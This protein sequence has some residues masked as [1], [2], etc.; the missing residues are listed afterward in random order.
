[1]ARRQTS[2]RT[3]W[4]AW[5]VGGCS[6]RWQCAGGSLLHQ[7][8]SEGSL[9]VALAKFSL[10]VAWTQRQAGPR[11]A[12]H[13]AGAGGQSP[14]WKRLSTVSV[15]DSIKVL[16]RKY[17]AEVEGMSPALAATPVVSITAAAQAMAE[18]ATPGPPPSTSSPAAV[19]AT[20]HELLPSYLTK[21]QA[22]E[23]P[24]ASPPPS[25]APGGTTPAPDAAPPAAVLGQ[26]EAEQLT[27]NTA[28]ARLLGPV[29]QAAIDEIEGGKLAA[30]QQ[31]AVPIDAAPAA[32]EVCGPPG[33]AA[34]VVTV[35]TIPAPPPVT[36]SPVGR[37]GNS[38][39]GFALRTCKRHRLRACVHIL[40]RWPT[41]MASCLT[42]PASCSL[43]GL[44]RRSHQQT[45]APPPQQQKESPLRALKS[46]ADLQCLLAWPCPPTASRGTP[47]ASPR[48]PPPPSPCAGVAAAALAAP[49]PSPAPRATWQPT[50]LQTSALQSRSCVRRR[51]SSSAGLRARRRLPLLL[52]WMTAS[53]SSLLLEK[54]AARTG[55]RAAGPHQRWTPLVRCLQQQE[56]W[57][58]AVWE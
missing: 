22:Y 47:V 44:L 26:P 56:G 46:L 38:T 43:Q 4:R 28:I 41:H 48:S 31:G 40:H 52:L 27:P 37:P 9:A 29:L 10:A 8:L 7:M 21:N 14:G 18:G 54:V 55:S 3:C 50:S 57:R 12:A 19:A 32:G 5:K 16:S 15:P 39:P 24:G 2:R 17:T 13:P 36:S 33:K 6:G 42:P 58:A 49:R 23:S 35:S 45:R 11:C 25:A 53:P 1:M 51:S 34:R 30:E 20:P